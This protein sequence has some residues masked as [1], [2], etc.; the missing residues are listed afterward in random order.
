MRQEKE[1]NFIIKEIFPLT[2]KDS[3]YYHL[4]LITKNGLRAYISFDVEVSTEKIENEDIINEK[5]P[6]LIYRCRPTMKYSIMLKPLP[7]P[8]NSSAFEYHYQTSQRAA[9]QLLSAAANEKD[10]KKVFFVD[11]K[12]VFFYKDEFKK[13]GFLDIVEYDDTVNLKADLNVGNI[14]N[15]YAADATNNVSFNFNRRINLFSCFY[16]NLN[17]I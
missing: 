15:A 6:N 7:E 16:L 14:R 9:F 10:A 17:K 5:N 8:T 3:K 4:I 13:Q 11:Q 12:F 1:N 2:R